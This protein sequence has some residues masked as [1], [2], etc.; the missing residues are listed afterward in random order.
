MVFAADK[1][2]EG[3]ILDSSESG[4]RVLLP[5]GSGLSEQQP[6]RLLLKKERKAGRIVRVLRAEDGDQV[7]LQLT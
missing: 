5:S 1:R 6:V 2:I 4:V 3:Q 7:C